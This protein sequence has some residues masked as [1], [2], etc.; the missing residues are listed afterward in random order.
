MV[1]A[2]RLSA[3]C[4]KLKWDDRV[5]AV[6]REH[7]RDMVSRHFFS[8]TNPEGKDPFERLKESNLP[9]SAAAENI[10]LGPR[11]G[12]EVYDIWIRSSGHRENMLNCRYT[13]HGVGRTEDR[14]T[15]VLLKP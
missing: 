5:A 13:R 4:P 2:K 9:F 8:H 7:S 12:K 3:G 11:T 14:W 15:H 6:A 1:N 10:A